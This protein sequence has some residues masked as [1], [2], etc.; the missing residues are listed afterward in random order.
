MS[1]ENKEGQKKENPYEFLKETIKEKPTDK[2]K[3]AGQITHLV[4]SGAIFGAV[5]GLVFSLTV[6]DFAEKVQEKQKDTEIRFLSQ[7]DRQKSPSKEETVTEQE[8]AEVQTPPLQ[9]EQTAEVD[10][11]LELTPQLYRKL[12]K[13]VFAVADTAKKSIVTVMGIKNEEEWFQT[14][15]DRQTAGL[16][17]A[18]SGQ[19]LYA[20]TECRGVENVD[21]I[22]VVFCDGTIAYAKFWREDTNTDFA[23]LKIPKAEISAYTKEI[24]S[25]APLDA[26]CN[27][28]QGEPVLAIGSPMG[29]SDSVGCGIVTSTTHKVSKI[30]AEYRILTTDIAGSRNGSGIILNL[31]GE[32]VG[33]IS[34]SFSVED[35]ENQMTGLFISEMKEVVQALSDEE[36][37]MVYMGITGET[38]TA[39]VSEKRG[40]PIGIFVEKV[41]VD[42]P[43]MQVGIQNGDILVEING[44]KV[45][46]VKDYQQKLKS[47]QDGDM[48]QVKAM[49]QGT[50]GYIEVSFDVTLSVR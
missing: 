26:S 1:S 35:A 39:E 8:K 2:K 4:G 13:D 32:V 18:E 50:E 12:Y 17:V 45:E 48:I 42:S 28:K 6:P 37:S 36:K 30:D 21:R 5:A 24:I 44:Q 3:L 38:V 9:K 47:Y 43:A 10:L 27:L 40:I 46:T 29:Y 14:S 19:D 31:N 34:Q 7:N 23:I 15:G 20:L 41:E 16:L 11:E 33:I 49:R 22:Q 25:I